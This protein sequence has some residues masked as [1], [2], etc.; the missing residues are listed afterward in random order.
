M[1]WGPFHLR[2]LLTRS[3]H[4]EIDFQPN[5]HIF[6]IM[7]SS[8]SSDQSKIDKLTCVPFGVT[9]NSVITYPQSSPISIKRIRSRQSS[10]G[11]L[12]AALPVEL[13]HSVLLHIDIKTLGSLRRVSYAFK[14]LV[15]SLPCYKQLRTYASDSLRALRDTKTIALHTLGDVY[16]ALTSTLCAVCGD[17]GPF[18]TSLLA[19]VAVSTVFS[20]IQPCVSVRCRMLKSILE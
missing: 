15:D 18:S 12:V 20:A 7:T 3:P 6:G 11:A 8:S 19:S 16:Y 10:L 13:Q 17:F 4:K 5:T 14:S 9:Y 1:R 2:L